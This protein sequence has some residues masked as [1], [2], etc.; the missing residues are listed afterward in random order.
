MDHIEVKKEKWNEEYISGTW[1]YLS[2]SDE[3][4]R[5]AVIIGYIRRYA[6]KGGILDLGC[7]AGELWNWLTEEERKRYLGVDI[8]SEAIKLARRKRPESFCE[9][10]VG[11]FKPK[12]KYDIIVLNEVLYY[13]PNPLQVINDCFENLTESGTIIISM[14][15]YPDKRDGEYKIVDQ[16]LRQLDKNTTY[17]ISDKVSLTNDYKWKRTWNILALKRR[18]EQVKRI[19]IRDVFESHFRNCKV[20][21][22]EFESIEGEEFFL[23][24]K[25]DEHLYCLF[26]PIKNS[27]GTVIISHGYVKEIP[28]LRKFK[29]FY[30]L[31]YNVFVYDMR[32]FG[33][34]YGNKTTYGFYE[35]YD[36]SECIDW[37]KKR[38]GEGETIGL[39]GDE[40]GAV[41]SILNMRLDNRADFCIVENVFSDLRTYLNKGNGI[42]SR[43]RLMFEN[44]HNRII[45]GFWYGQVSPVS[46]IKMLERPVLF[47]DNKVESHEE[48]IAN[49]INSR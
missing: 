22:C 31:G 36:L 28:Y 13:I 1:D 48:Q 41:A 23:R 10:D 5:Y 40:I 9:G 12:Q 2:Q 26:F 35:K 25:S 37:V 21:A 47:L 29:Q 17:Y 7:G 45:N 34:S 39:F 18:N 24:L 4:G 15:I 14:F 3:A 11:T 33:K 32:G 42:Y 16:I 46:E 6:P 43:I 30:E 49:F 38:C 8:S 27:R 20:D 44:I 19:V